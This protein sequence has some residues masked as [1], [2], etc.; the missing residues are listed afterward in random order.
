[1][2]GNLTPSKREMEEN[3]FTAQHKRARSNTSGANLQAS[4]EG[5]GSTVKPIDPEKLS[6]TLISAGVDLKAEEAFLKSTMNES[7][8][9]NANM[10]SSTN[11][12]S[13]TQRQKQPIVMSTPFLDPRQLAHFMNK[14]V[15]LNG[16]R[17]NFDNESQI[18]ELLTNATQEWMAN[19]ITNSIVVSRH[20]RRTAATNRSKRSEISKALRE[21]AIEEKKL[22]DKRIQKRKIL[23]IDNDDNEKHGSDETLHKATNATVAMMTGGNKSKKYSWMTGGAGAGGLGGAS[24]SSGN[25]KNSKSIGMEGGV[26][27]REAREEPG[28]AVRDLLTALEKKRMG[29]ENVI[30]KGYA[31]LKD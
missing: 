6:D 10:N 11:Q 18:L 3:G 24:G 27:F 5:A 29:V 1:M 13:S 20:R 16:I 26:R 4:G 12:Q 15:S 2:S 21:I 7:S 9:G 23:G 19:I 30:A 22:E 8:G 17:Q 14:I 25:S 28:I 31:N